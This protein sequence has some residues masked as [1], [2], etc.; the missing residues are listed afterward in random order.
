MTGQLF[1][2]LVLPLIITNVI[3]LVHLSGHFI[4]ARA[5]GVGI[6]TVSL[7]LGPRIFGFSRNSTSWKVCWLPVGGYVRPQPANEVGE[8][9]SKKIG[10][11]LS[12]PVFNIAF[13]FVV[14]FTLYSTQGVPTAQ[15]GEVGLV[16]LSVADGFLATA[17]SLV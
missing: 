10:V 7:G 15:G 6:E 17:R 12:G 2:Y 13:A 3:V 1:Y 5:F 9:L 16:Q 4:A 8:P 14:F 11:A